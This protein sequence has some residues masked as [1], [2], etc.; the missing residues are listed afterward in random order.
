MGLISKPYTFTQGTTIIASEHNSNFDTVY[1]CLNGNLENTNVSA[2][3][4]I[5][6]SKLALSNGIVNADINSAAAIADSKLATISTAGKVSAAAITNLGSIGGGTLPVANGGTGAVRII[7][8]G[9][10]RSFPST[11]TTDE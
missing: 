4:A 2:G 7:W 10:A 8:P 9:S 5:A 6:Y 1:N 11:R 3:A